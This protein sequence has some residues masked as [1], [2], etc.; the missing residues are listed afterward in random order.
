MDRYIITIILK[1]NIFDICFRSE[2]INPTLHKAKGIKDKCTACGQE[3][4]S[5][6]TFLVIISLLI[7]M[8]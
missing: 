3:R 7:A 8:R 6:L 5:T 1:R 2:Q 4:N